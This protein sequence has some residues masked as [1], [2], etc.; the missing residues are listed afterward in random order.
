MDIEQR[1]M[2]ALPVLLGIALVLGFLNW[3]QPVVVP[4]ALAVLLTFLLA[5]LSQWLERHRPG[6]LHLQ[7]RREQNRLRLGQRRCR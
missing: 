4:V 3:A 1:R 2:Q 6:Q 7:R 5:P